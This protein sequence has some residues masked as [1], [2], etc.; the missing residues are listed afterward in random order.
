MENKQTQPTQPASSGLSSRPIA[1]SGHGLDFTSRESQ[2]DRLLAQQ[3]LQKPPLLSATQSDQL[4]DISW[5]VRYRSRG[6][7]VRGAGQPDGRF[8]RD[9][10]APVRES[11]D[12]AV[13]ESAGERAGA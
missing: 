11:D 1:L 12:A 8:G 2:I 6:V 5:A 9:V 13:D 4:R 3:R 10:V 7:I